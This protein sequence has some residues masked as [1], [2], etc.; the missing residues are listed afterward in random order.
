MAPNERACEIISKCTWLGSRR[1]GDNKEPSSIDKINYNDYKNEMGSCSK[2]Y[3]ENYNA[4]SSMDSE[5]IN[6]ELKDDGVSRNG[7]DSYVS[8]A[9]V[10]KNCT[11]IR[12]T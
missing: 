10:E 6:L 12:E 8:M 9:V 2:V 5:N 7:L 3:S 11:T 1:E 4:S